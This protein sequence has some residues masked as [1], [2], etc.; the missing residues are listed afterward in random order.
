MRRLVVILG[1]QLNLDGA[2]FDDFHVYEDVVW[3]CE[4]PA[5]ATYVWSHKARIALFLS[6]MRHFRDHL[7]RLGLP[8]IYRDTESHAHPTLAAALAHDL[9]A[10]RPDEVVMVKAGEW[11]LAQDVARITEQ[12]GVPLRLAPDR[13]FLVDEPAFADWM[14]GRQ[15]PRLEHFYRWMRRRTGILMEA[16]APAGG[17]WNFDAENRRSFGKARPCAPPRPRFARDALTQEVLSLVDERYRDHPGDL[18]DFDWPV[19]REQALLALDRFIRERLPDF[20]VWQDAMWTGEAWLWRVVRAAFTT[21]VAVPPSD[22]PPLRTPV[23]RET[24]PPTRF[25]RPDA[26]RAPPVAVALTV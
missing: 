24:H 1:D 2:V 13:H 14:Q 6:A 18:S 4:S 12:A 23:G 7:R 25:V 15:T 16:D 20:G 5:E 11:R 3:M 22:E 17:S 19:T 8:V 9:A 26:A 10:L 21:P